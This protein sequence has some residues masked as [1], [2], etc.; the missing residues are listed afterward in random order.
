VKAP[1]HIIALLASLAVVVLPA[2]AQA[3]EVAGSDTS[4]FKRLAGK[5]IIFVIGGSFVAGLVAS[6]TPC[7][8]PMVP[9]TVSIFGATEAKSRL[10]GAALSLAF[11]LGIATLLTTLGVVAAL[12]GGLMGAAMA[13]W[14]VQVGI[15]V[16]FFALAASMFGAFEMRLPS[17]LN[18]KLS[19]VGGVG[20]LGAYVLGLVMGL[21]A[22]PC[23]GPFVTGMAIA[24]GETKDVALGAIS[25]FSFS[26]GLGMI[27]FLAGAFA[28]NLPK[29]GAWMM[30]VKWGSGVALAFFGLRYLALAVPAMTKLAHPGTI[31]GA[32]AAVVLAAGCVLG[33]IHIAAEKRKSK[34]AHLSKR[35]KLMSIVPAIAGLYMFV[36]WVGMPRHESIVPEAYATIAAPDGK[37]LE[38]QDRTP[39]NKCVWKAIS[40][41]DKESA[42]IETATAAKKPVVIDFGANWCTACKELEEHTFP[43]PRVRAEASRFVAIKVDAVK[44]LQKKYKVVGL[45]TVVLLDASGKEAARFTEFV[46]PERFSEALKKVQ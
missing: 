19:S 21:V 27:F 38:G 2:L 16:V 34:I 43:D 37:C 40:W 11:I 13:K 39:D 17:G 26:I 30:L 23:T 31:Y 36:T 3:Q 10:R 8:F 28:V 32:I 12:T 20:F 6:L 35:M 15:A 46:P 14:Y 1:K 44:A 33:G 42:G 18:N 22:M 5:G 7:V 9:I 25:M 29:A 41:V 24:I 4:A 45:P